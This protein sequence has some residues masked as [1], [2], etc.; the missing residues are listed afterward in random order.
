MTMTKRMT[1]LARL[2]RPNVGN[3]AIWL[4]GATAAS[5]HASDFTISG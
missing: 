2:G 1:T 3:N 5:V 4:D